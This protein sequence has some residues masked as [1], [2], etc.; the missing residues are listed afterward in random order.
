MDQLTA[1]K[2]LGL[3]PD[4]TPEE[5]KEAYASLSKRYHPEE[6]PEKFE[7]IHEAY[8]S[9]TRRRH[10]SNNRSPLEDVQ[11]TFNEPSSIEPKE[12]LDFER[13]EPEKPASGIPFSNDNSPNVQSH[14]Y[15]FEQALEKA[16]KDEDAQIHELVLEA[17]AEFKILVSPK[18]R[19]QLKSFQAFFQ[20]TKYEPVIR[21]AEFIIR[22]CPMLE[23]SQLKKG[24]YNYIVDFYHLRGKTPSELTAIGL[25]LYQILD[26]KVK[27]K[28]K[29]NPAV[30]G[31]IVAGAVFLFRIIRPVIRQN[32]LLSTLVLFLMLLF[33][34]G[35][36]G[37]KLYENHSALFAQGIVATLLMLSQFLFIMFDAYGT[38][39]GTIEDGN[40]FAAFIFL[41]A[42]TWLFIVILVGLIK[43]IRNFLRK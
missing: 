31:G 35:W 25:R 28:P 15:A 2:I 11:S 6:E 10:R 5:I 8:V 43:F 7:E 22:L 9:L 1:Y 12:T 33:F 30:Y 19:N 23:E 16:Q 34:F 4:C 13:I 18:Y 21:K 37:K 17:A 41:A 42:G 3:S 27:I 39:F 26:A 38:A 36:I 24:I 14:A 40:S 32:E 29:V 20:D